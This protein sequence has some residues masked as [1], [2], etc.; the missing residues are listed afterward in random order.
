MPKRT[1]SLGFRFLLVDH[2]VTYNLEF[3][4]IAYIIFVLDGYERRFCRLP[5]VG[6][7]H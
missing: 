4:V 3:M 2:L 7:L 6:S 1:Q 5:L